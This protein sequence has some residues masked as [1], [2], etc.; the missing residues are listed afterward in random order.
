MA[1]SPQSLENIYFQKTGWK[2]KKGFLGWI[3]FPYQ[4]GMTGMTADNNRTRAM[5]ENMKST[6]DLVNNMQLSNAQAR[7]D[8]LQ[9]IKKIMPSVMSF[10][11]K[12]QN[13]TNSGKSVIN[14][15]SGTAFGGVGGTGL[16]D[17][18]GLPSSANGF[19]NLVDRNNALSLAINRE[20]NTFNADQARL[21][22]EWAE[23]MSN[24]AHQREIADLKAAGLNPVLSAGGSGAITP[25]GASASNASYANV[26]G[27]SVI[28]A[29]ASLASSSIMANATMTAAQTAA[30]A[31]MYS[32]DM[33]FKTQDLV[34]GRNFDASMYSSDHTKWGAI[35]SYLEKFLP[36]AAEN[37]NPFGLTKREDY[38]HED[39]IWKGR[40]NK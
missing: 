13:S 15:P 16:T 21:Q 2:N 27:D 40:Y 25:S 8:T 33:N 23:R 31:S 20:N 9:N 1:L 36:V 17:S 38:K 5:I 29:L 22:R 35:V 18:S 19:Q 4:A 10:L 37:F 12:A 7:V 30:N 32:S 6:R 34:S 11:G 3:D 14:G 28:S 24:T 39:T 26:A